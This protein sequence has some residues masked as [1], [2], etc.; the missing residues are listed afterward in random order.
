MLKKVNKIFVK[1]HLGMGDSVVHNGMVRKIVEDNPDSQIYIAAKHHYFT[2]VKFMFR[3]NPNITVISVLDDN[4]MERIVHSNNFD[5]IISSHFNTNS[6]YNYEIYFDDAFYLIVGMDPKIKQEYFF[7]DR[8][9]ELEEKVFNEL[10][11]SKGITEYHFVHEKPDQNIKIK[12][13]LL[14]S[15]YPVITAEPQYDMFSLLKVIENAKSVNIISSSFL[16]LMMCKKFNENTVAHM[17]CDRQ[18]I[19]PYVKKHNINVLE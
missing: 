12:R 1:H 6:S 3:D 10:I 18:Y 7:I 16:S 9:Y 8:D 15:N 17:Y 13:D 4:E 19:S 5:K 14:D 11:T 2:N